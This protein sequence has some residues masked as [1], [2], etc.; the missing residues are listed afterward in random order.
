M[1][2]ALVLALLMTAV[3]CRAAPPQRPAEHP[4]RIDAPTGRLAGPP[5]ILG[6]AAPTR[7]P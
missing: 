6:A 5:A 7:K 2:H 3:G 4:A 1:R